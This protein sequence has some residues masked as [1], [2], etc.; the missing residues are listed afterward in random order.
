[1]L[2]LLYTR[3][4]YRSF[5]PVPAIVDRLGE[6]VEP[7]EVWNPVIGS[8]WRTGPPFGGEVTERGFHFARWERWSRNF[9]RPV[10]SGVFIPDGTGTCVR[11]M[12]WSPLGQ[13]VAGAFV[14]GAISTAVSRGALAG[15]VVLAVGGLLH[16]G[17]CLTYSTDCTLALAAIRKA[18]AAVDDA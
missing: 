7:T 6:I 1:M 5:L 14:V 8:R 10:V 12:V 3:V 13:L 15:L 11:V 2:I 17:Q 9:L 16:A 4:A 18:V